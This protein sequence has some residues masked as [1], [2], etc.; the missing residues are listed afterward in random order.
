[1]MGERFVFLDPHLRNE[2]LGKKKKDAWF[3]DQYRHPHE[4]KHTFRQV[5]SWFEKNGFRF[6]YGIPNPKAFVPFSESDT[7]F[8]AHASGNW[9]DHFIV[10][11]QMTFQ[12]SYEGGFFLMIGQRDE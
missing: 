11:T 6:V 9:L 8:E 5:L 4:S 12:G 3:A 10:Q 1:M 7:I 2:K